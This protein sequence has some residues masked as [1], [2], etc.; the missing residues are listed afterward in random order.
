LSYL[1]LEDGSWNERSYTRA[2]STGV[3]QV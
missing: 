3:E 1:R 2:D